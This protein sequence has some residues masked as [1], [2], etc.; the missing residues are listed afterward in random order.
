MSAIKRLTK[1]TK[2]KLKINIYF[3]IFHYIFLINKRA[4]TKKPFKITQVKPRLMLDGLE[5]VL[6]QFT[7]QK[8]II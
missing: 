6:S 2:K 4:K 3:F 1:I 8:I 5:I 7:K